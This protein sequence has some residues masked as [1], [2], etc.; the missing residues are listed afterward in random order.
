MATQADRCA[1]ELKVEIG[2]FAEAA[3]SAQLLLETDPEG[4]TFTADSILYSCACSA[5]VRT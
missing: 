1:A 5:G 4:G 2:K 3:S